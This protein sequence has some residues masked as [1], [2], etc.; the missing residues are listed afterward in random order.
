MNNNNVTQNIEYVKVE[1]NCNI[2]EYNND[3]PNLSIV[4]N[5]TENCSLVQNDFS[6]NIS[7]PSATS[8]RN[9]NTEIKSD[10]K[11]KAETLSNNLNPVTYSNNH[12]NVGNYNNTSKNPSPLPGNAQKQNIPTQNWI[13]QQMVQPG[14]IPQQMN[15]Q[16]YGVV[17]MTPQNFGPGQY[18]MPVQCAYPIQQN[19]VPINKNNM[20]NQSG[21]KSPNPQNN[22]ATPPPGMPVTIREFL[23]NNNN[24]RNSNNFQYQYNK[25][26]QN[27]NQNFNQFEEVPEKFNGKPV[28]VE[29]FNNPVYK[30]NKNIYNEGSNLT[31]E[32]QDSLDSQGRDNLSGNFFDSKNTNNNKPYSNTI[33]NDNNMNNE[34]RNY[35]FFPTRKNKKDSL[36]DL[37]DGPI[38]GNIFLLNFQVFKIISTIFLSIIAHQIK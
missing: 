9:I 28:N 20:I 31:N 38:E 6:K 8:Q 32:S 18:A 29:M 14:I 33:N 34:M 15:I 26:H 35:N 11:P 7:T 36:A 17:F 27:P 19:Q 37:Y 22:Y 3:Q 30:V 24:T 16:P 13:P 12:I 10:S 21:A 4:N 25:K 1:K 2:Q 23:P 5:D